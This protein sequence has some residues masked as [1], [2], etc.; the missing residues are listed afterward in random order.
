MCVLHWITARRILRINPDV[1]GI[2]IA[3]EIRRLFSISYNL[4]NNAW[5]QRIGLG[6]GLRCFSTVGLPQSKGNVS[7]NYD[8]H[9]FPPALETAFRTLSRL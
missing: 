5:M 1:I 6:G 9:K 8:N 4:I 7:Y 2:E 3:F